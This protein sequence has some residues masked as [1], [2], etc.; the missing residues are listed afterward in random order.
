LS[1]MSQQRITE[2]VEPSQDI[3]IGP[4]LLAQ[5]IKDLQIMAIDE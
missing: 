5:C 2:E 3:P 1:E 4:Y